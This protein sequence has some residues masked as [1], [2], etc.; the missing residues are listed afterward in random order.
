MS[1]TVEFAREYQK[2]IP[3]VAHLRISTE[4]LGEGTAGMVLSPHTQRAAARAASRQ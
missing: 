1:M 4:A 3:F 2:R